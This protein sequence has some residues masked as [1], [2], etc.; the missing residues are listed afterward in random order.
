MRY[1]DVEWEAAACKGIDVEFYYLENAQAVAMNPK[2]RRIC[3]SCPIYDECLEYAIPNEH[4]GFWAGTSAMDRK[5][6]RARMR[7]RSRAA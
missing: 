3:E 7:R 6:I 1:E 5:A 2:L 4:H